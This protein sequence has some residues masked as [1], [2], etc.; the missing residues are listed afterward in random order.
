MG[1]TLSSFNWSE[2]SQAGHRL[3]LCSDRTL[4]KRQN[5]I[6]AM[7][8]VSDQLFDGT[9]LRI[10]TIVDVITRFNP[11]IDAR[12]NYRADDVINTLERVTRTYGVP[13]EICGNGLEF[14]SRALDL[15]AYKNGEFHHSHP[16]TASP[17]IACCPRG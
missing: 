16:L 17:P 14:I 15:W 6:W 5:E 11:A 4:A 1:A 7:D 12:K 3:K 8:F 9:K 10:L 2:K 13:K